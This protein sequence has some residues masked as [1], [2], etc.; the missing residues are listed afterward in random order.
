[1]YLDDSDVQRL[2]KLAKLEG[3]SQA[4]LLRRAIRAY[5]PQPRVDRDFAIDGIGEGP[6]GSVADLDDDTLLSGFGE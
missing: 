3:V 2:A 4:S 6:G 5:V 1:M